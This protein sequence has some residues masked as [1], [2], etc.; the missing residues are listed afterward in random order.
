MDVSVDFTAVTEQDNASLRHAI[1][2]KLIHATGR[3]PLLASD[4]DWFVAAALALR[5]RI[6]DSWLSCIRDDATAQRKRVH[7]LSMEYLPGRLLLDSLDNM[8]LTDAMRA[9][10][11]ELGVD[12]DRIRGME[13]DP[14]LGNGGLGRLAA[15][16]L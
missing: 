2:E 16:L 6:V 11:A 14:A 3:D 13:P 9:A 5:D 7:Y 8:G 4:R 1:Y 12:L 15:C 10:L